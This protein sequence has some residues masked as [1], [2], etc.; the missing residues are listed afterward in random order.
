MAATRWRTRSGR[1]TVA[2]VIAGIGTVIAVVL[3]VHII[4]ALAGANPGN[5][6]VQFIASWA[7]TF[8]L[9]FVGIFQTGSPAL[10]VILDYGLAAVFWLIVTGFFARLAGR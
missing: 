1:G 7:N 4:F 3:V 6:L 10:Q 8:A 5:A 9:W 2:R